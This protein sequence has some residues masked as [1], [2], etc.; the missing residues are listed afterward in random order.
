MFKD[1]SSPRHT[2]WL[3]RIWQDLQPTPGRLNSSLRMTLASILVLVLM[4][5][6][7]MPYIAYGLYFVFLIGRES[8][9]VSLRTA[10]VLVVTIML[11]IVAEM[12]VVIFSDD[13]PMARVLSVS[14][15]TFVGGMILVSTSQPSLGGAIG[16]IYCV[17]IGFWEH[18]AP[19]DTL[20]KNS[21]RLVA[22]FAMAAA[23]CVAVE[24]VFG[25]RSPADRLEEQ[26]RIRYQALEEMFSLCAQEKVSPKQ[27]F[28][29]A[30]RVSRLAVAGA[31][32]MMNLYN[33]IVDR[34][35]DTGILPVGTRVHITMLAELMD[36]SAA[37]GLQSETSDD[38]EFRQRCARIAEQCGRLIPAAIPQSE[39]RL[40][41]GPQTPNILLDRVE[42]TIH[43]IL[44][45]P[46]DLGA[47]KNK[48]LAVVTSIFWFRDRSR[49]R[50]V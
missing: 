43:S 47:A 12:V 13:D 27:R 49:M 46:V 33:Q 21:L 38:L 50:D 24:Y 10:F 3:Q 35:L 17:V 14:T 7:Q 40:E 37:F 5:V 32:G 25:A 20:V 41:P 4:L 48:E 23:C 39:K 15:V 45:M 16:F 34:N 30:A 31:A 29:A 9:A 19:E 1:F 11:V 2:P 6:L 42:V 36:N 22:A 28:D 8:P 18:Q 44:V 26:F